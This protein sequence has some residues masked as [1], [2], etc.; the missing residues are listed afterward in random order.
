MDEQYKLFMNNFNEHFN[1]LKMCETKV[2]DV[3]DKTTKLSE[4]YIKNLNET[5]T[6]VTNLVDTFYAGINTVTADKIEE[7]SINANLVRERN[8]FFVTSYD[9]LSTGECDTKKQ[10]K[11]YVGKLN[12]LLE[13]SLK[14]K[15]FIVDRA[16][17]V[18]AK[19]PSENHKDLDELTQNTIK[20]ADDINIK[21]S[22]LNASV[23]FSFAL[24]LE[25]NS[26]LQTFEAVVSELK[27]R[28]SSL[29]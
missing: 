17:K 29:G 23:A 22:K 9:C 27:K 10:I 13:A 28:F 16:E 26:K 7:A 15:F 14:L 4:K 5:K 21:A 20:I 1:Q 3:L 25:L 18:K 6:D 8:S 19:F 24:E 12:L 2:N 11:A